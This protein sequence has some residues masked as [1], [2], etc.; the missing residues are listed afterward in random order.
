MKIIPAQVEVVEHVQHIYSYRRCE[1]EGTETPIVTAEMPAPMYPGSLA[2]PWA[3]A[4]LMSQKYVEG[5]PLYRQ[6]KQLERMG[7]GLSRQTMADWMIYGANH[8]LT[9]LHKRMH[10]LLLQHDILHADETVN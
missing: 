8:W 7:V 3:M 1:K 10:T 2:S 4:Y 9:H 5:L 6:E